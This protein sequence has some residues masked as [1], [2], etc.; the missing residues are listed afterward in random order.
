MATSNNSS[1]SRSESVTSLVY[2]LELHLQSF[3]I[4]K[5]NKTSIINISKQHHKQSTNQLLKPHTKNRN[6]KSH[7]KYTNEWIKP[8]IKNWTINKKT[9]IINISRHWCCL[10]KQHHKQWTNQWIK[11]HTKNRNKKLHHY[12]YISKRIGELLTTCI[13]G[14]SHQPEQADSPHQ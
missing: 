2:I 7:Y 11:A 1:K 5:K 9:S 4:L 13:W 8:H 3:S 6:K 14:D 12:K 10:W